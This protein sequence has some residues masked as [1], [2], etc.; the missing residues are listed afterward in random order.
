MD[1]IYASQK[2]KSEFLNEIVYTSENFIP[3]F[4]ITESHLKSRHFD[5]EV[6]CDNYSITRADRPEIKKGGVAIYVHNKL[7]VDNTYTYADKIC[8]AACVYSSTLNL[9]IIGVY[10]PPSR[11]LPAEEQSFTSCLNKIQEVIRKHDKADIQIHGDLNFPFINWNTREI[12]RASR[13]V[14]EQNSARNLLSFMGKNLLVQLVTENTRDD[15]SI[16][17]ILLTNNEQAIHSVTTEK[18][19]LSDHDFVHCALLYTKLNIPHNPVRS[20]TEKSELDKINLNKADWEAIR[21]DISEISWSTILKAEE[22]NVNEMF[23]IF[24]DTITKVCSNHAPQHKDSSGKRSSKFIPKAR[25]SLLRTRRH[26]T[27]EINK[28]KYL[29]PRNHKDKLEKLMKKK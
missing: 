24:A 13:T 1:T 3:Y 6:A 18:T 12:N 19:E 22:G 17:D 2:T 5:A 25:R 26:V 15:K 16:L 21:T 20:D 4:I 23:Q 10:R 29:K 28:C 27:Y 14:S 11:N 7:S 9:L 8:Q